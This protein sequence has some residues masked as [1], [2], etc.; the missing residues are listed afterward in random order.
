MA[1]K[2]IETA[3]S[4]TWLSDFF[5]FVIGVRKKKGEKI[6]IT[7]HFSVLCMLSLEVAGSVRSR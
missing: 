1:E 4:L 2:E 5:L 6:E 7:R 3:A